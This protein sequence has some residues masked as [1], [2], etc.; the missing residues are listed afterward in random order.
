M[1]SIARVGLRVWRLSSGLSRVLRL[2][3]AAAT[4]GAVA[5]FAYQGGE[6]LAGL[7]GPTPIAP[8]VHPAVA[9][10]AFEGDRALTVL[11]PPPTLA[12]AAPVEPAHQRLGERGADYLERARGGDPGS[13]CNIAGLVARGDGVA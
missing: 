3:A 13:Q 8:P 4:M 5:V 2:A 11:T 6:R 10:A 9:L 7:V 1:P 12:S